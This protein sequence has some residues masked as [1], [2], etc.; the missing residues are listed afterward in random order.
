MCD[1]FMSVTEDDY[2]R[3][4][5]LSW[6]VPEMLGR[7]CVVVVSIVLAAVVFANPGSAGVTVVELGTLGGPTSV[8]YAA[9]NLGQVAGE[10]TTASGS[11]HAFLWQEG[12]M[13]DL[14]TLGGA[15]SGLSS[16]GGAAGEMPL[17]DA[18]QVVGRSSTSTGQV[19]G[20]LWQDGAMTDL[21]GIGAY[22][23][24]PVSINNLGQVVGMVSAGST[25]ATHA[26]LWED[27]TVSDFGTLGGVS[28]QA[29]SINDLGQIV[30]TVG[31]GSGEVHGFF[32]NEGIATDLGTL[33]G[34]TSVPTGL[35]NAGQV[36][37]WSTT[38]VGEMHGFVWAD[39]VM[40]DLGT[41]GGVGAFPSSINDLGQITG[42][43]ATSSGE[44]HAFLWQGGVMLDLGTLGGPGSEGRAINNA[45]QIA[46]ISETSKGETRAF[47]W[48]DGV[49]F[50]LGGLGGDLNVVFGMNDL[51]HIVGLSRAPASILDVAVRWRAFDATMI[52]GLTAQ[53]DMLVESGQIAEGPGHALLGTAGAIGRQLD[54]GHPCQALQLLAIFEKEVGLFGEAGR[55]TPAAVTT[56]LEAVGEARYLIN[57][58]C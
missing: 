53:V 15:F 19:R 38:A 2:A 40:T 17:N 5:R 14:G 54:R 44:G 49:M 27:G 23:A 48:Q 32:W 26:F 6:G 11:T 18:G 46:G 4:S 34:G 3:D 30:G 24:L 7:T 31:H 25:G 1:A 21:G 45:G 9:N 50:D 52:G 43:S 16:M 20:F 33:G 51:G 10:S 57:D 41:L 29:W 8:A 47:L 39:G 28:S 56:L 22:P 55:I 36:V 13:T 58:N 42:S 37:G 12:V 35:N